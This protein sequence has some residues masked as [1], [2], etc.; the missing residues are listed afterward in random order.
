MFKKKRKLPK[1]KFTYGK[2]VNTSSSFHKPTGHQRIK[3]KRT[4]FFS[5][6]LLKLSKFIA[7]G[8]ALGTITY[9]FIFSNQFSVKSIHFSEDNF[10]NGELNKQ[11][12]IELKSAIGKNL[13]TLDTTS[14]ETNLAKHFPEL[15]KVKITKNYPDIIEVNFFEYPLVANI[16]N[17][18]PNL[19]KSYII[20]SIGYVIK[21]NVEKQDLPYIK[22]TSDEPINTK[23][24]IISPAKLNYILN[25]KKYFEDKF[26]MRI[27]DIEYKKT[28]REVHLHTEKDFYIW[29]DI[30]T[31]FEEQLKKLKKTIV[32]LDIYKES[33]LYIDLRIAGNNG[34]KIIY[35]R[36]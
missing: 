29:L 26:G 9:L 3:K 18:S 17:E 10:Q 15:Q 5:A 11:V 7:I 12:E 23:E 13:I 6:N 8:T 4:A 31:P 22:M 19:K 1:Y 34:D 14:Y 32:K 28:A 27:I 21:E 36:K 20:N 25:S 35:K 30:E 24:N 33:L 16:Q 2:S